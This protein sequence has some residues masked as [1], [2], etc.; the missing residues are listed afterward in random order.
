[1]EYENII[2]LQEHH[3]E[4]AITILDNDGRE[5]AM[6]YLKQWDYGDGGDYSDN[7]PWGTSDS[8]YRSG[9]YIMTFNARMPYIGLTKIHNEEV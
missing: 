9:D 7:P 1:M 2:F 6:D 5:A 4:E 3:A 8:I